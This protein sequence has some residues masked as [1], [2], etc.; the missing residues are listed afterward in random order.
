MKAVRRSLT[1]QRLRSEGAWRLLAADNAP[2]VLGLL[3]A[4]LLERERRLPAS[5]LAERLQQELDDLRAMGQELPQTAQAY[6]AQWLAAG[7]L[8]RSYQSDATEEEY[9][10]SHAAIQAIRFVQ[11]LEDQRAVATESRLAV[12]MQQLTQLAEQTEADPQVRIDA[13]LRER[14]RIDAQIDAI[15]G[16]RLEILSDE[17]ALERT[18]EI[19]ALADELSNDFRRVRDEF[20]QLNRDLRERILENDDSRGQVLEALFSGVDVIAES[21]A[22]RTFKAFWR[23]LTDPEQSAAYEAALEQLMERGF[24]RR[25]EREERRFL[26]GLTRELL[27]RGGDVHEVLQHFAR[28][29]KHFVQSREYVEQRRLNRLLKQAQRRALAAKDQVKPQDDIGRELHLTSARIRSLDQFQMLDPSLDDVEG[30]IPLAEE[31]DISLEIVGELVAHSEIDFRCLHEHIRTLLA[32]RNQFT[33]TDLLEAYPAEQGLG[34]IVGYLAI[35]AR[36]GVLSTERERVSWIGLD[37]R[38]RHATIPR[39]HFIKGRCEGDG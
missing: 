25:L 10:L 28:G 24:S 19:V 32:E 22:G 21:E 7:Y 34:S 18:R 13:L 39:I 1:N 23:L 27:E 17:Q 6:M 29:L 12:V 30:G 15:R 4:H 2:L 16:G 5:I 3:Q 31:A 38:T 37:E 11:T 8:E 33:V 20:Q 26:L 36:C 14:Q 35:G 9:E